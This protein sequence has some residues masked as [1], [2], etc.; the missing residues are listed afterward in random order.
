MQNHIIIRSYKTN[1]VNVAVEINFNKKDISLVEWD[2][3]QNKYKN[4]SWIFAHR[5]VEYMGGWTH[6]LEAMEHAI[7]E[8]TKELEADIEAREQADAAKMYE[9][10]GIVGDSLAEMRKQAK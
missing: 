4:K 6:V 9:I 2:E 1:G 3:S 10:A 8:A 5:G 7:T